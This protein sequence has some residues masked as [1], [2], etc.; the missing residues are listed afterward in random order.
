LFPQVIG[1]YA[2]GVLGAKDA[3]PLQLRHDSLAE[4]FVARWCERR[5]QN[6]PVAARRLE[7][8]LHPVGD[9]GRR[10][11]QQWVASQ[12]HTRQY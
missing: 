4:R 3:T 12:R 6:E 9:H 1:E 10:A 8:V 5:K 2:A 7:Q 11:H